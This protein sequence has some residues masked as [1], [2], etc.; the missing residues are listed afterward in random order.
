M[1]FCL[2]TALSQRLCT[3]PHYAHHRSASRPPTLCL[4]LL[5]GFILV[6]IVICSV[7][8]LLQRIVLRYPS[9]AMASRHPWRQPHH[10]SRKGT[11]DPKRS[12]LSP[13]LSDKHSPGMTNVTGSRVASVSNRSSL[14]L[15]E[16]PCMLPVIQRDCA[17]KFSMLSRC[18]YAV[19][20]SRL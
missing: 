19:P 4:H 18:V 2:A 20:N 12:P 17:V 15:P 13:S 10:K 5:S 11:G 14:V 16:V 3:E 6:S 7:L 8:V 1:A 9:T